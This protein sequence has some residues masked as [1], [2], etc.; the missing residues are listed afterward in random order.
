[1]EKHKSSVVVH[2]TDGWDRTAQLTSL[3]MLMLDSYYRTIRGF[4]VRYNAFFT[5]LRNRGRE[6]REGGRGEILPHP[7]SEVYAHKTSLHI[8]VCTIMYLLRREDG[9][10]L[11]LSELV[12]FFIF[13]TMQ[14]LRE[15]REVWQSERGGERCGSEEGE[16]GMAE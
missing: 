15:E 9:E 8:I 1:M 2:C 11:R 16:G 13:H 14:S 5:S 7:L 10:V 3:A 4:E 12:N 6:E